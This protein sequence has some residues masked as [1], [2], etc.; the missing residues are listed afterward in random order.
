MNDWRGTSR[1]KSERRRGKKSPQV[2]RL[3]SRHVG[4]L[5]ALRIVQ[6]PLCILS[7]GQFN[8]FMSFLSSSNQHTPLGLFGVVAC[9]FFPPFPPLPFGLLTANA[10]GLHKFEWFPREAS[11]VAAAGFLVLPPPPAAREK[12]SSTL[13]KAA[14]T[15]LPPHLRERAAAW[16]RL[17]RCPRLSAPQRGLGLGL[18][19]LPSP[20]PTNTHLS[21][22]DRFRRRSVCLKLFEF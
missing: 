4:R 22:P 5:R 6:L 9:L 15:C 21:K 2:L 16:L 14:L 11:V 1:S 13:E 17:D 7:L 8:Y 19:A 20:H 10:Q 12:T 3:P 18:V